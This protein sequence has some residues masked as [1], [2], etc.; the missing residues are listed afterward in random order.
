V[1]RRRLALSDA[2][3]AALNASQHRRA[4]H[5]VAHRADRIELDAIP[6]RPEVRAVCEHTGMDPYT[7]I[8]EGT[9]ICTVVPERAD[10]FVGA[11]AARIDAGA[12]PADAWTA[13]TRALAVDPV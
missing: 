8:S 7:A 13:T 3:I 11:L 9:L 2:E 1:L 5:L 4:S 12:P 10:D 6:V